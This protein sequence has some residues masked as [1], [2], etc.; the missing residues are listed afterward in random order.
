MAMNLNLKRTTLNFFTLL[1][2]GTPHLVLAQQWEKVDQFE[3]SEEITAISS[4]FGG[5][6][7]I[8]TRSGSVIKLEQ[9]GKIMG[10][11]SIPGVFPVTHIDALNSLKIF[12][13]YR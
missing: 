9:N 1:L 11:F 7:F 3:F 10:E 5:M 2:L 6:L 4:D 13:W 8:G 12:V